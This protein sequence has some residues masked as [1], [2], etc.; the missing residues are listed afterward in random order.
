MKKLFFLIVISCFCLLGLFLIQMQRF[1]DGK[2]H[3]IFCDVGQG[4]AIF[5]RTPGGKNI[6]V[7]GGPDK[8]VLQCLSSN[9]PFWDKTL[10]LVFLT[11]PH[12]D[13]FAGIYY[14][15]DRYHS[16]TFVTEE[17]ANQ[18]EGYR[19]FVGKLKVKNTKQKFVLANDQFALADGVHIKVLGPSEKYLALTSPGGT[20]GESSE[21]A[22]LVLHLSYG[23]FDLVLTGDSQVA[24]LKDAHL[25][26]V[27]GIEVLQLPHH[28]SKTGLD[29][30]MIQ[31]LRPKLAVASVGEN[32]YGHPSLDLLELLQ[33]NSIQLRRTD[34]S[35]DIELISD[36]TTWSIKQ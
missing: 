33:E 4:D 19:E 17:L 2:L 28:G 24:G 31:I 11:H 10:H 7:D 3:V 8:S 12:E 32:K 14:V 6:L 20:I 30:E 5:I 23:D 15:A 35:G 9:M 22:S 1:Y 13:H 25:A 16:L 34:H 18:T 21:F 26:K 27:P 36:G 29:K